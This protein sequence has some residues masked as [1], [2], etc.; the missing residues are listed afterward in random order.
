M[1]AAEVCELAQRPPL[2]LRSS[3]ATPSDTEP[4]AG[5]SIP[6]RL[7]EWNRRSLFGR[8]NHGSK[9]GIF[10]GRLYEN[11]VVLQELNWLNIGEG[12]NSA[13]QDNKVVKSRG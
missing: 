2:T 7:E 13:F 4:N 8:A 6:I 11:G 12:V 9:K 3:L 1:E 10:T 5:E